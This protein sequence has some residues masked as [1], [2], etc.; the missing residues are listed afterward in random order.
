MKQGFFTILENTPLTEKVSRLRLGG[1]VSA[2]ERPGQFADLRLEGCF[3]RRPFSVCDQDEESFTVLYERVGRGTELLAALPVGQS[4]DVLTGLGNGFDPVRG[5]ERPLLIGGGTGLSPLYGLAK[6]LLRRGAQPTALLGFNTANE[7]FYAEEFAAL[8]V[9]TLV[10]TADGSRGVPGFVTAAMDRDHTGFY[11]CGPE[12]MLRAVCETSD[13]PGQL[14]F[15]RRMG[16]GFGAC[17]GCTVLTVSGPRRICRDGP[18]L[19]REDV[20]WAD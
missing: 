9:E 17:M 7:V 18:V 1:D 4:L 12:A 2:V 8:G 5:G 11:A 16:C 14:S 6:T 15:D 10:C 3:L 13:R 20:L 19:D